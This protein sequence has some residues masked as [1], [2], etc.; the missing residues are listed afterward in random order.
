VS[1]IEDYK[2]L[3]LRAQLAVRLLEDGVLT[4]NG[5]DSIG[6]YVGDE[7]FSFYD[8]FEESK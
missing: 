7:W 8:V 6:Y 3:I 1:T 5:S 4:V 2:L